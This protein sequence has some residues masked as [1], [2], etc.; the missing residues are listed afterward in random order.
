MDFKEVFF[1]KADRRKIHASERAIREMA[2]EMRNRCHLQDFIR[3]DRWDVREPV[4]PPNWGLLCLDDQEGALRYFAS[5]GMALYNLVTFAEPEGYYQQG[6]FDAS[7]KGQAWCL[8][9]ILGA[10]RLGKRRP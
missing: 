7:E 10:P 5:G 3:A 4:T 9:K 6:W 2:K 1:Q 8:A